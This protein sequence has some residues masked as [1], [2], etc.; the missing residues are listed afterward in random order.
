MADMR[1]AI[2]DG[3]FETFQKQ[4]RAGWARGDLEL[5]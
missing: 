3:R 1:A 5:K 4:T 2:D